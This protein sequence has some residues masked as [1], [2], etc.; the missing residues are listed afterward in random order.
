MSSYGLS[1]TNVHIIVEE[2]PEVQSGQADA[3]PAEGDTA[4]LFPLSATSVEQL[5][6][7]AGRLADWV[8]SGEVDDVALTDLAYTLARR[9]AHRPVRAVVSAPDRPTLNAALREIASG[10]APFVPAVGQSDRGPVWVFSGGR[11]RSGRGWAPNCWRPSWFSRR[12]SPR[13]SRL[14]RPSPVFGYRGSKSSEV[15]SGIDHC[16]ADHLRDAGRQRP[17]R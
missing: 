11:V 12:R 6:V 14:F 8:D 16:A 4:L 10:S 17:R 2:A 13:S 7:T 5:R 9:R 3:V 15:V 1:G